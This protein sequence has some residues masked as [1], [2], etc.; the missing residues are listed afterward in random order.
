MTII[1]HAK[2]VYLSPLSERKTIILENRNCSGVYALICRV[3]NKFYVGSSTNL[4]NRLLDYMQPA[5]LAQQ[6]NRPILRAIVKYGLMN[7]I[8]VVLE[9]CNVTDTLQREQYW[10]DL[11]EPDYNLSPKAGS[12]LGV[13]LSEET[14]AKLRLAHLGK[15]HTLETRLHMSETR[16]GSNNPWFGKSPTK[17]TRTKMSASKQGVLNP[18]FGL[19]RSAETL[20]RMRKNHPNSKAIYQYATD[21]ITFIAKFY[22]VRQAAILTG[23]SRNYI[24]RCLALGTLAH[25]KWFFSFTAPT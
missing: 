14:K 17:E 20:D 16:M 23:L 21:Q 25:G 5:Y 12:T 11:L 7:F 9:T 13:S 10:L 6:T 2:R 24:S 22:S 8:F 1:Y 4:T 19:I 3:N 18:N 15:T